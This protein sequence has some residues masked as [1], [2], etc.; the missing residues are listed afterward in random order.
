MAKNEEAFT[1][2]P[3]VILDDPS[4]NVY[5][6]RIL[7]HI[8]RQ[9]IGYSK[10]SDGISLSQ[11]VKFTNMGK[12]KVVSTLADLKKKK[13]IKVL[14]QTNSSGRKSFNKYTLLIVHEMNNPKGLIVHE[15]NNTSSPHEPSLV[16]ETVIQKKIEQKKIDKRRERDYI[17]ENNIYFSISGNELKKEVHDFLEHE[18]IGASNRSAYKAK[19]KR[20]LNKKHTE[21]LENFEEWY[22]DS[23]CQELGEKYIGKE[24]QGNSIA[25]IHN[26]MNTKG[27]GDENKFIIQ[28]LDGEGKIHTRCLRKLEEVEYELQDCG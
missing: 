15:T 23:K 10:K 19:L 26:Y 1:K 28:T 4:L 18:S 11:F 12:T 25:S 8:A 6:F 17:E 13:L 27:F 7:M 20:Q 2:V 21:T 16:R 3:N 9:T 5:E 22:L 14:K 24:Y